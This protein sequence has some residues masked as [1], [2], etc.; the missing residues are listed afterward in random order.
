MPLPERPAS[1]LLINSREIKEATPLRLTRRINN[2]AILEFQIPRRTF[3]SLRDIQGELRQGPLAELYHGL[4]TANQ[5]QFYAYIPTI[6]SSS[7]LREK[8][9][10]TSIP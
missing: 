9:A 7:N 8:D 3:L 1:V 5:S 2:A 10:T 4:G 6:A